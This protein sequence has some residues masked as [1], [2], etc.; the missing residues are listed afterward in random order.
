MGRYMDLILKNL[1]TVLVGGQTPCDYP[2]FVQA[3]LVGNGTPDLKEPTSPP[4]FLIT[5]TPLSEFTVIPIPSLYLPIQTPSSSKT[6][7]TL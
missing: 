3:I 5:A 6:I 2:E 1:Q 4:D 7:L